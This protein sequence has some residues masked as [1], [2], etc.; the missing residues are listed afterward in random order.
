MEVA[1]AA[2]L[3]LLGQGLGVD[4]HDRRTHELG[5]FYKVIGRNWSGDNFE[6][7][8]IG[9][10]VLGFLAAD[11]VSGKRSDDNGSRDGGEQNKD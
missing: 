10:A 3:R 1:T 7:R 2:I 6:R 8:C 4:V 11:T 9:A 5:N